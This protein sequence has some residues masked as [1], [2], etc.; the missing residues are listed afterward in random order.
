MSLLQIRRMTMQKKTIA[1]VDLTNKRVF[2]RV[3]F[4][5]PME[6]GR[7]TDDT[8]IRAALP[9]IRYA[10]ERN[11]K[12]ILAS[13]FGRP[14]GKP[15]PQLSLQPVAHYL[16]E[17]L[18]RS[19]PF[20][21]DCIGKTVELMVE[22]TPQGEA[23]LLENVRF[24]AGEEANDPEFARKLARLGEVYVNDAF[25]AAHRAHASTEGITRFLSPCVAGFLMAAEI[26]AL[27]KLLQNPDSPFVAILGGA[28]ISGKIDVI[29]NLLPRVDVL[30][31]G[32]GMAY[33]FL[34]ARDL[35]VGNSLV[36][37][38][39]L[40]QAH[41][42][43]NW[44]DSA[45]NRRGTRLIL[46]VDHL[47]A[48]DLQASHAQEVAG[49]LEGQMGVDIG[50]R[51]VQRFTEVIHTARTIFWNGPMGVFENP[52]FAAG[53]RKIAEAVAA[54]TDQGA[55]S[56]VGGGDSVAALNQTGLE[57]HISHISTGG[58]ASLEFMAGKILP[59]VHALDD[60]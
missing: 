47:V 29:K 44:V 16:S 17:C 19:V 34:R 55:F 11:A 35:P 23:I 25:G 53:T 58:G 9:T 49:I 24:H 12:V 43:L 59:G 39:R 60:K 46:P 3:D 4:N 41:E 10:T 14:K 37:E 2:M 27:G 38:D 21:P 15:A 57:A 32:G 48:A 26:E 7:V 45:A 31:I 56:V 50:S 36:E 13:H 6:N 5:V 22:Q 33:T 40:A 1:D 18:G 20:A 8:R 30:L 28:K 54:A 42:V 52:A 51:T